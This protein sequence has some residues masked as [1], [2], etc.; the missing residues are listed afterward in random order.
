RYDLLVERS[1]PIGLFIPS[2][3][4]FH[5]PAERI[6]ALWRLGSTFLGSRYRLLHLLRLRRQPSDS[7][8]LADA[9][10]R[11]HRGE[12]QLFR[13][14]MPYWSFEFS[15]DRLG[16][17]KKSASLVRSMGPYPGVDQG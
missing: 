12:P 7:S 13:C 10:Q 9:R 15:E 1:R 11:P 3:A 5:T 14:T 16:R 4:I 6:V 17:V 2:A 8:R